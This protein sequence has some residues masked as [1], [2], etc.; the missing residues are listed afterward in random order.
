[1]AVYCHLHCSF[2]VD[3]SVSFVLLLCVPWALL[4]II[5]RHSRHHR[6]F[7]FV[8]ANKPPWIFPWFKSW[9][10][11]SRLITPWIILC[12]LSPLLWRH[13]IY[14]KIAGAI[15]CR[16]L[17]LVAMQL[18]QWGNNV[19][20]MQAPQLDH[21]GNTNLAPFLLMDY[22]PLLAACSSAPFACIGWCSGS[23]MEAT[24]VWLCILPHYSITPDNSTALQV[25]HN[26]RALQSRTRRH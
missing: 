4:H 7:S 23:V 1:M 21:A 20:M 8:T 3:G 24:K 13:D 19:W 5:I 12:P 11:A 10:R 6:N 25:L 22:L 18:D 15:K 16:N 26:C 17:K 14:A 9:A 2:Q